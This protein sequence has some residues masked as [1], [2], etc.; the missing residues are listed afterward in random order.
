MRQQWRVSRAGPAETARLSFEAAVRPPRSNRAGTPRGS[1]LFP[2]AGESSPWTNGCGDLREGPKTIRSVS[3]SVSCPS[4]EYGQRPRSPKWSTQ[5][6]A[7]QGPSFQ[8]RAQVLLIRRARD[9]PRRVERKGNRLAMGAASNRRPIDNCD[10][11]QSIPGRRY[12]RRLTL[13]AVDFRRREGTPHRQK[14]AHRPCTGRHLYLIVSHGV[15]DGLR[16]PAKLAR[17]L[18]SRRPRT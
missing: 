9:D 13:Q 4:D 17:R 8:E 16:G 6:T 11:A 14:S 18:R 5:T 15:C 1:T 10:S 3:R 7:Q 2:Q 12:S